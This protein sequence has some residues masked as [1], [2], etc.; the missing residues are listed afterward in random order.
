M[1]NQQKFTL[2]TVKKWE[3]YQTSSTDEQQADNTELTQEQH[4]TNTVV[5]QSQ[6]S[7]NTKLTTVKEVKNDKNV[8]NKKINKKDI[9]IS[10]IELQY[11][12]S[13]SKW[14]EYRKTLKTEAQWQYQYEKLKSFDNFEEVVKHSIGQGYQ[15]LYSPN[16]NS[17]QNNSVGTLEAMKEVDCIIEQHGDIRPQSLYTQGA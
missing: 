8:I 11:Q 2:I 16:N 13:L 5:T 14:L 10:S 1:Q 7:T 4:T 15:G 3:S 6:H 12:D 9:F 17:I